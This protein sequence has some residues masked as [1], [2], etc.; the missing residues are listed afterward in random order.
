MTYSS[1]SGMTVNGSIF[2]AGDSFDNGGTANSV[3]N[4]VQIAWNE[5][6]NKVD[7]R[8][9]VAG[10]ELGGKTFIPGVYH[11]AN[12]QLTAGTTATMDVQNDP[13]AAFIFKADSPLC[14]RE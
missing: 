2:F 3:T 10:D 12:L 4:D 14:Q 5:G 11:N 9:P 7:T 6:R 1:P 8:G 13:N